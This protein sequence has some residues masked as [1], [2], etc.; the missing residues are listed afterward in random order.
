MAKIPE[1][2]R[3]AFNKAGVY[4]LATSD[5]GASPN[6][7]Y[8][9]YM[10]LLDEETILIADNKMHKTLNNLLENP[11]AA[12]A[13]MD[14]DRDSYQI[15][16]TVDYHTEDEYHEDVRKWCKPYLARKGAFVLH[17]EEIYNG[18]NRLA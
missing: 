11:K 8:I 7:V 15:K 16:G 1:K 5:N 13:F 14:G 6:V 18:A 2:V 17:V 4:V 12:L 10:K 9:S 3:D